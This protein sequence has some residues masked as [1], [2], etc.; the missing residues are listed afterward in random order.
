MRSWPPSLR[1]LGLEFGAEAV[2]RTA[3]EILGF[4]AEMVTQY[5]ESAAVGAALRTH[6]EKESVNVIDFMDHHNPILENHSKMRM[7]SYQKEGYQDIEIIP[8]L[9]SNGQR[10]LI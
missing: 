7:K 6:E 8:A 3:L 10:V 5:S 9:P 1:T 2:K 4:P